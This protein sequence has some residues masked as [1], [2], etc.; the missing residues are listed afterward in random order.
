MRDIM[1]DLECTDSKRTAAIVSIGAVYFDIESQTL[2]ASFYREISLEGIKKQLEAGR[3]LSLETM[4]WWLEQSDEARVV[5]QKKGRDKVT[6]TQALQD[7]KTFCQLSDTENPC[8]WGNGVD[9]DNV[10][11]RDCYETFGLRA[12][13][14]YGN[15][16]CYRTIK[17][18]FK[19]PIER[20]GDHHNALD[21]A[22]TQAIHLIRMLGGED[23]YD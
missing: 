21:D 1:L 15:N 16:R 20:V 3:T 4:A 10:V 2:G 14:S 11:L 5:W 6:I 8:V 12:P 19:K 22:G 18:L 9:Y 17:N 13:W 7:F 23:L